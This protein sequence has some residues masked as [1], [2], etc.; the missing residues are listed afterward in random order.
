MVTYPPYS[1]ISF[2][3]ENARIKFLKFSGLENE[4]S[5]P[6]IWSAVNVFISV[7]VAIANAKTKKNKINAQYSI[8]RINAMPKVI[9]RD[10]DEFFFISIF[11]SFV[12]NHTF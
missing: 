6:A 9:F 7:F 4:N 1:L 8:N 3:S 2:H 11:L 12:K 10:T 5:F